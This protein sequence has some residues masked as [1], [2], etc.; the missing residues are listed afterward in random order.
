MTDEEN[1]VDAPEEEAAAEG[2]VEEGDE[3]E[4]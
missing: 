4:D 2:E 1:K 3:A